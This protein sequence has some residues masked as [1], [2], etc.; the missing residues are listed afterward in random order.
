MCNFPVKVWF[1]KTFIC[2]VQQ[3]ML[4]A[5]KSP[6]WKNSKPTNRCQEAK[7]NTNKLQI[8]IKIKN[9]QWST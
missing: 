2:W 9:Y 1:S 8:K 4:Y 5:P 7:D 3:W 6:R